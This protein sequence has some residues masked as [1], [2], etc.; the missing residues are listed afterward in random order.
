MNSMDTEREFKSPVH[1]R[2]MD[3]LLR[4]RGQAGERSLG[5]AQNDPFLTL[6]ALF[7]MRSV[8]VCDNGSNVAQEL[9]LALLEP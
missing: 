6:G 7:P 5:R 8:R 4:A 1:M 3:S 9:D 2:P